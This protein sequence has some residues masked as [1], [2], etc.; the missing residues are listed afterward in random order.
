MS[1]VTFNRPNTKNIGDIIAPWFNFFPEETDTHPIRSKKLPEPGK[2]DVAV[3]GGG[4]YPR[5]PILEAWVR[6]NKQMGDE[7][8]VTVGWG[9]GSN[10]GRFNDSAFTLFSQRENHDN[11]APCPSCMMSKLDKYRKAKPAHEVVFYQN[12]DLKLLKDMTSKPL[13]PTLGNNHPDIDEVLAFLASGDIVVT[14]SYHG[15]FWAT[16]LG[17]KVGTVP[18]RPKL[19]NAKWPPV[20]IADPGN[21]RRVHK[22]G[23]NYPAALDEARNKTREFYKKFC[24]L[25]EKTHATK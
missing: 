9:V 8:T 7:G 14:S 15:M 23:R 20:Y 3:F 6:K 12:D 13:G 21:W 24:I 19:R 2:Y 11:W 16:M 17:R 5:T 10:C 22:E 1:I 4:L 25:V 18:I